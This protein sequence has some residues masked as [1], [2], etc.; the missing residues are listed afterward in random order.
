MTACMNDRSDGATFLPLAMAMTLI[1]AIA[2][3]L[4]ATFEVHLPKGYEDESGFHFGELPVK[5]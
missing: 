5:K 4:R 1:R 3:A 2:A